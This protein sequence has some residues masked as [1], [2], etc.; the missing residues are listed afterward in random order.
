M[1]P[2]LLSQ[3]ILGLLLESE[4]A[5]PVM[6]LLWKVR[7][8]RPS[9]L[10]KDEAQVNPLHWNPLYEENP[11]VGRSDQSK[12]P[13]MSGVQVLLVLS[14]QLNLGALLNPKPVAVTWLMPAAKA[15]NDT[16]FFIVI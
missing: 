12:P 16:A 10:P 2:L 8:T 11:P 6:H 9:R 14:G 7:P 13:V 15:T 5:F 1:T 4:V 3:L